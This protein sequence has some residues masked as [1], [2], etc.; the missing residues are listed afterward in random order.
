MIS[1]NR[2]LLVK[3]SWSLLRNRSW[4][5]KSPIRKRSLSP[6]I[7][8]FY[9]QIVLI[10]SHST[11]FRLNKQSSKPN[12]SCKKYS[13]STKVSTGW[14]NYFSHTFSLNSLVF[15]D[16]S[17]SFKRSFTEEAKASK[18]RNIGIKY[19]PYTSISEFGVSEIEIHCENNSPLI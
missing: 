15:F 9:S 19:G 16:V 1:H 13:Y 7:N 18:H 5:V 8:A 17:F 10:F 4:I 11:L 2:L 3:Q 12:R 6:K 14:N